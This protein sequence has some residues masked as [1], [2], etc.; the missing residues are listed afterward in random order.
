MDNF[1]GKEPCFGIVAL[2]KAG[3]P[4]EYAFLRNGG[5]AY[6]SNRSTNS[7]GKGSKLTEQV[8]RIIADQMPPG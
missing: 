1:S 4:N 6:A 2:S 8:R 7:K 3:R 5:R